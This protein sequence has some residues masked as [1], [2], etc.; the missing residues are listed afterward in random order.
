MILLF[1]SNVCTDLPGVLSFLSALV[2][3]ITLD[4]HNRNDQY[5]LPRI[6]LHRL[7]KINH[8]LSVRHIAV[9]DEDKTLWQPV[10]KAHT[11][12]E[13]T[14]S[15]QFIYDVSQ[16]FQKFPKL[17]VVTA[18]CAVMLEAHV[19]VLTALLSLQ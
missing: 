1:E 4:C 6:Y 14:L 16:H 8:W 10:H 19:L 2:L 17:H 3:C 9:K 7:Y 11:I 12:S 13:D 15:S 5:V 18:N